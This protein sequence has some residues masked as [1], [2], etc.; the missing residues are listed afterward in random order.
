MI[1]SIWRK[2]SAWVSWIG[3][4]GASVGQDS[5]IRAVSALSRLPESGRLVR[6]RAVSGLRRATWELAI[7]MKNVGETIAD[8]DYSKSHD[9]RRI[10]SLPL[11]PP[12]L[13]SIRP[14]SAIGSSRGTG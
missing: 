13:D 5:W 7:G 4:F 2:I 3:D 11:V 1:S 8:V 9:T 14:S 12:R 10:A 6:L